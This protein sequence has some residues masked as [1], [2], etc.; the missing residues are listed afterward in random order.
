MAT[1]RL[2]DVQVTP[3]PPGARAITPS[4]TSWFRPDI[5][6]LRAVAI[7]LV[8]LFHVGVPGFSAGFTGVDIFFVIS[9]YLI[10]RK[11]LDAALPT[12]RVAMLAFWA[13]RIRRLVPAMF[14]MVIVTLAASVVVLLV[15]D[16]AEVA[17]QGAAAS[18]YV[19][20][21]LFASEAG[22]YFGGDFNRSPFLHTWTL[23]VEEQFY[24]LWPV[25]VATVCLIGRRR[26][27][28][29]KP[30]LCITFALL[31]VA[32]L[33]VC[34]TL[35]DSGSPWAFYGLPARAWEFAAAGLLAA[36]PFPYIAR[37]AG[38]STTI[39]AAGLGTIVAGLVLIPGAAAYPG[40]W[41]LFPVVGTLL[42]IAAGEGIEREGGPPLANVLAAPPMQSIGRVSY[43]WYLWH[44]P[45]LV[46]AVAWLNDDSMPVR[47]TAVLVSLP[48][49]YLTYSFYER[50][51]RFSPW[52]TRS[53]RRTFGVGVA[54]TALALVGA[55]GVTRYAEDRTTGDGLDAQL[56]AVR[57]ERQ[58]T[59]CDGNKVKSPGGISYCES[60][61]V[62]SDV[63]VML[64][65]DSHAWHWTRAV[66]AAGN[67]L[68]VR[69]VDH[70]WSACPATPVRTTRADPSRSDVGPRCDRHRAETQ[71]LIDELEPAV[72]IIS[73]TTYERL[74]RDDDGS[75]PDVDE[76]AAIWERAFDSL[77]SSLIER[78]IAPAVILDS[79]RM[80]DDPVACLA[81]E[82]NG[83]A[84]AVPVSEMRF[85]GDPVEQ[86]ERAVLDRIGN[87]AVFDPTPQICDQKFCYA[88]IGSQIVYSDGNHLTRAFTASQRDHLTRLIQT[89]LGA[90]VGRPPV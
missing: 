39:A 29:L 58:D 70:W 9:G 45:F 43:S 7:I 57:K 66:T 25:L 56:A 63:T 74:M 86:A 30:L 28:V 82:R 17:R 4:T 5:D 90:T 59:G 3:S 40:L 51:V 36:L 33:A 65:G 13:K 49:A 60:G 50:P 79:P 52:L 87:V 80:P 75:R 48:V 24:V 69:V 77:L 78:G 8:V 46:L 20:N 16:L 23:G 73:Q 85:L 54:L 31:L 41:A 26:P 19:S 89:A 67:S 21:V 83:P 76:A 61:A 64:I 18:L 72:V 38:L 35:T 81:R 84:C 11:L 55:A 22:D 27:P 53:T 14:L 62:D 44:W 34:V 15:I 1:T 37:R 6:G 71:A 68:G 88:M 47:L 2:T 32:S 42:V 10:T 12:G